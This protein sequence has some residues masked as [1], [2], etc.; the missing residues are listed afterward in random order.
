[1][2]YLIENYQPEVQQQSTWTTNKNMSVGGTL[3]ATGALT[4]TAGVTT[5]VGITALNATATTAGGATAAALTMG[6]GLFGIYFGSGAPTITAPKGSIYL[7]SDGVSTTNRLYINTDAST[8][9][10]AVTTQA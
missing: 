6:T 1:M 2:A 5:P 7:R 10:T 3:T 4:A 8:T 9:W